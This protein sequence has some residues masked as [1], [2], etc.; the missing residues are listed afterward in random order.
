MAKKNVN[1]FPFYITQHNFASS[2]PSPSHPTFLAHC[3]VGNKYHFLTSPIYLYVWIWHYNMWVT[4]KFSKLKNVIHYSVECGLWLYMQACTEMIMPVGGNNEESIFPA[5]NWEYESR[6]SSCK[7]IFDVQP[8]PHWITTEFGGN[9]IS[10][11]HHYPFI[12]ILPYIFRWLL[13]FSLSIYI[14]NLWMKWIKH[15][16]EQGIHRALKSSASN[17]IF[18]NGLRDPWSAGGYANFFHFH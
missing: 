13:F 8:R 1:V 6:V 11:S 17:I 7:M 10:S 2:S 12:L 14:S 18:F 15:S 3:E 4:F 5:S 9:V 16:F